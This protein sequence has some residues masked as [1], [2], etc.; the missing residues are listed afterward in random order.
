MSHFSEVKTKIRNREV[1]ISVL[2][3]LGHQIEENTSGVDV[4]GFMGD[5]LR[6]E[7]KILTET[8]YDIGFVRNESGD[9]EIVADW[10]VLPKATGIDPT[11]FSNRIKREYA[12]ASILE[13]AKAQGLPVECHEQDG[14][15]E[16]VVSQW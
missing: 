15:I 13:T 14:V 6:A 16:M 1:L 11:E 7:F 3:S 12:R 8:H 5:K 9:Y 4:R 10:E 2:K